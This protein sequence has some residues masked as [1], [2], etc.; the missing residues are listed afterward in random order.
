M[1]T[2]VKGVV[3]L[4]NTPLGAKRKA[5]KLYWKEGRAMSV[6]AIPQ[7]SDWITRQE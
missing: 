7:D 6:E 3:V 4:A 5:E 2:P 1:F